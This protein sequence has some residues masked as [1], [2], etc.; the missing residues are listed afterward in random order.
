LG[1]AGDAEDRVEASLHVDDNVR[2]RDGDERGGELRPAQQHQLPTVERADGCHGRVLVVE[3]A[4]RTESDAPTE[5]LVVHALLGG[6]ECL[7]VMCVRLRG[8]Q[9]QRDLFE[10]PVQVV[11]PAICLDFVVCFRR[12]RPNLPTLLGLAG[13]GDAPQVSLVR[14]A[15]H[16][17]QPGPP[18]LRRGQ[19]CR[20]RPGL[21]FHL[22]HHLHCPAWRSLQ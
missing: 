1:V 9:L 6:A 17:V 5:S 20:R 15:D 4:V 13:C 18:A 10:Q 12:P 16:A 22:L 19:G 7:A 3:M 14:A 8:A 2:E 11:L 21:H